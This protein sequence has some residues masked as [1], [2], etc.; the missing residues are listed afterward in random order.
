[1]KIWLIPVVVA[2]LGLSASANARIKIDS[3]PPDYTPINSPTLREPVSLSDFHFEL[4]PER[5][6]ARVVVDYT[7]P[8]EMIYL[9]NDDAKGPQPTVVQLPGLTYDSANHEVVYSAAGQRTI[10]ATVTDKSGVF[11]NHLDVKNT[12]ACTVS[13]VAVNDAVD[14]GWTVHKV[15]ALDI[16]LDVH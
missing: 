4:N 6:R 9:P 15:P 11:G 8:D 2:A 7:Y 12:G 14:D 10:C 16:Y 1:M 5:T 13:T 3:V